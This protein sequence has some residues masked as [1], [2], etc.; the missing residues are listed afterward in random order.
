MDFWFVLNHLNHTFHTKSKSCY[1]SVCVCDCF[2]F[3]VFRMYTYK[4]MLF[5]LLQCLCLYVAHAPP[6]TSPTADGI[7]REWC[8][9]V[10]SPWISGSYAWNTWS[11]PNHKNHIWKTNII[12]ISHK[13]QNENIQSQ[14]HHQHSAI[15]HQGSKWVFFAQLRN[16]G[17]GCR[18]SIPAGCFSWWISH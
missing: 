5:L 13:Y 17:A 11:Y 9:I 18:T 7:K 3:C 10:V 2:E 16:V 12:I 14:D 8:G 1:M 15:S 6:M 4:H